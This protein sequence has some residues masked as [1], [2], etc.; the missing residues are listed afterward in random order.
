VST[1]RTSRIKKVRHVGQR[2]QFGETYRSVN[3]IFVINSRGNSVLTLYLLLSKKV[4]KNLSKVKFF[5]SNE[6]PNPSTFR[7]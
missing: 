4:K 5:T 6:T 2:A 1:Q 7:Q 3:D